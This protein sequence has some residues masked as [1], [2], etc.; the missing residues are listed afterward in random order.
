[1]EYKKVT[2]VI[3]LDLK[4]ARKARAAAESSYNQISADFKNASSDSEKQLLREQLLKAL[5]V[6]K[7]AEERERR[8]SNEFSGT[9]N[10]K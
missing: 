4:E 7:D 9:Q 5:Q 1:M 6:K 10:F 2:E 3:F 8:L